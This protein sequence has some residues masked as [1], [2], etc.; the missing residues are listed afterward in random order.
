MLD[1]VLTKARVLPF[2]FAQRLREDA[3]LPTVC[4]EEILL[5]QATVCL[6]ADLHC[7]TRGLIH[8]GVYTEKKIKRQQENCQYGLKV[9]SSE[10]VKWENRVNLGY[11]VSNRRQRKDRQTLS[12]LTEDDGMR[13]T[14]TSVLMT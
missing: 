9:I 1:Q 6:A 4:V 11:P 10:S 2:K 8:Y 3:R 14:D 13:G 5:A 7:W 12:G